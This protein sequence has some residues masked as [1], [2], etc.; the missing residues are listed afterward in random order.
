M[1]SDLMNS[2]GGFADWVRTHHAHAGH[3]VHLLRQAQ[4]LLEQGGG[5]RPARLDLADRLERWRYQHL[6]EVEGRPSDADRRLI[7]GLDGLG[8]RVA[9][10]RRR[11]PRATCEAVDSEGAA[12]ALDRIER[13]LGPEAPLGPLTDTARRLTAEHFVDRRTGRRRMLLYAPLYLSSHCVNYCVYCGFRYPNRI[14]RRHLDRRAALQQTDILARRGFGRILLVA[15][16]FPALTTTEYFREIIEALRQRDLEA[17]VEIA[18]QSAGGYARLAEAGACGVTLYQETYDREL[19]ALYH[20][21]GS[22]A[23]Y[24][25]RLEGLD[26]AGE[27]GIPRL[28]LGVL[29]GLAEP[30]GELR[31]MVRHAQYL[32]DRFPTHRL[33]FSLP[34]IHQ[35]PPGFE[36]PYPVGDETLLR[37][38]CALRIAFP[39]AELVLSTREPPELRD[40]LARE[41]ITQFSAGSRT[42][43]GGYSQACTRQGGEQFPVSDRRTPAEV[44]DWLRAAGFEVTWRAHTS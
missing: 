44:A 25:W 27:S 14:Q 18:P 23:D 15:G 35:A 39:R 11:P 1:T 41:C 38:Y 26:R 22:K 42:A 16:D 4:R 32:N 24:H 6:H 17:A 37:M 21:Q 8:R 40:R 12:E 19:Y 36:T 20:P 2:L 43:P 30:W 29:L 9:G 13:W 28:G 7:D 33:A 10:L 31:A 34:R 5:E 3:R